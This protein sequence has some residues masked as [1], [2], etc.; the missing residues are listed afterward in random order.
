MRKTTYK[1]ELKLDVV[2]KKGDFGY[3]PER[4]QEWINLW[5]RNDPTWFER[6]GIDEDYGK[7]TTGVVADFQKHFCLPVTGEVDAQTWAKLS[8]PL[9]KAFAPIKLTTFN[10]RNYI[11]AYAEQHL[12]NNPAELNSKNEGPWVRSYMGGHDGSPWAWCAGFVQTILDLAYSACDKDIFDEM[13]LTYSC[14]IIGNH[15]LKTKQLLRNKDFRKNPSVVKPG[16]VFLNVKTSRDWVHTGIIYKVEGDFIF[17]F[18]GN[19]NDEGSRE[20]YEV[21]KRRRNFQT[22][23]IDVFKLSVG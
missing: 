8:E 10:P 5:R 20:G 21:C 17:T 4:V 12:A 7:L 15:G 14:D 16:D 2:L 1:K 3:G 22:R 13:P 6:I 11:T 18:E 23:N 9:S 19:T